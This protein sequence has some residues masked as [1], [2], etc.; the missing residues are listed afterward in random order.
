MYGSLVYQDYINLI[1]RNFIIAE[2][3][4]KNQI[5][6]SSIDL[7]LS[8]EC[9]EIKYSF[10]SYNLKDLAIKKINL[11]KEFIFKKNKTYIVRL[12]ES[13]NL[14]NDIFGHCNPKSSTGRLDIFC[15]SLV[16]YAEEYEK[17]P[18]NYKGEIFLEITSRSFDVAFKK[19]N[20]LNQ[21]RLVNKKHNYLTDKQLM[22]QNKKQKISNQ[23][24]KDIKIDS[25]IKLSVD[26]ARSNIIAYVAKKHTPVLNFYKIKCHKINDFWNIINN[27]NK[28][29]LIEK[30]KFYI[31]KSK[32]KVVI[33]SNLAG[34]MV[35]YD[36]GIGDFRAHYA[37]FFDPGFGF[38]NGSYAV[39][40]VKTNEVPF[41]LEDSQTIAR[42]KYEKLNKNSNVVYG[43]DI[44]SN[45]QNQGLKLSKHFK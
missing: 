40:E 32:E 31:L 45:Y 18:K 41:L 12:N 1:N 17:I 23:T 36:T 13:L 14:Q 10:L 39:L 44:K 29:L 19:N 8:E 15:R 6:P 2:N 4:I 43:K 21:L 16:D 3:I 34:E 33:P 35:P 5:Q 11:S 37:G 25:G 7:S 28:K 26:L 42:I 27:S 22:N 24:K 38:P 9:Y 30:N 20:C